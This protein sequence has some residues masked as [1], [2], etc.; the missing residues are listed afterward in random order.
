MLGTPRRNRTRQTTDGGLPP[1]SHNSPC[2]P[3]RHR[4][5]PGRQHGVHRRNVAQLRAAQRYV[6]AAHLG[7]FMNDRTRSVVRRRRP[8][9]GQSHKY[10]GIRAMV[11]EAHVRRT[12]YAQRV[13]PAIGRPP[14]CT[15]VKSRHADTPACCSEAASAQQRTARRSGAPASTPSR[16]L[17]KA[18]AAP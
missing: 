2:P 17:S 5:D 9:R 4:V 6:G 1:P 12:A 3:D 13:A 15:W 10:D 14:A 11:H 16:Q 8:R 7:K 18:A